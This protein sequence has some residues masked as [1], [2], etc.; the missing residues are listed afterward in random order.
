MGTPS[1]QEIQDL[2]E[3][4]HRPDVRRCRETMEMLLAED[5]TEI[6]ASGNLYDRAAI[7]ELLAKEPE[8]DHTGLRAANYALKTICNQA[9]LLTYETERTTPDGSKRRVARSSIWMHNGFRWQM[10]FHQGTVRS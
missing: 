4:L 6:G 10:L 5:F 1:L 8:T 9:V 3:A 7:I 2:E